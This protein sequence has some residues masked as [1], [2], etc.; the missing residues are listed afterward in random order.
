MSSGSPGSEEARMSETEAGVGPR[1]SREGHKRAS[2]VSPSLAFS[3]SVPLPPLAWAK[4]TDTYLVLMGFEFL[5]CKVLSERLIRVQFLM[6]G[7][8]M[9]RH[10]LLTALSGNQAPDREKSHHYQGD[11]KLMVKLTFPNFSMFLSPLMRL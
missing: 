2:L 6:G 7:R 1:D 9:K 5:R 10:P 3:G 11:R 8:L 4:E